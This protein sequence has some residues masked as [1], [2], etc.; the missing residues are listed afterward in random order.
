VTITV[1]PQT[2]LADQAV[3]FRVTGLAPG[4]LATVQTTSTDAAGVHWHA[5]P[6]RMAS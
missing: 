1:Q 2:S 5:G 4:E 3:R 6:A